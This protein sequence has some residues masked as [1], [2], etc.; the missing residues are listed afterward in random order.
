MQQIESYPQKVACIGDSITYGYSLE[1]REEDCYPA[2]L[3]RLLGESFL[4]K[5]YGHNGASLL[6]SGQTPYA[7]CPELQEAVGYHADYYVICLGTNDICPG[8]YNKHYREFI[9]DYLNLIASINRG[10]DRP[11]IMIA[12][13]PPVFMAEENQIVFVEDIV[14][15]IHDDV[16]RIVDLSDSVLMD[17]YAPLQTKREL[18]PD[19]LHPNKIGAG[20][21]AN[22]VFMAII[23][24]GND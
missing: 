2:Q 15:R 20:I 1:N 22:M 11:R 13:I 9:P 5:N 23:N 16:K 7:F 24:C 4:V 18:F 8:A 12:L 21:I 19:G 6:R 14:R 17:F 10:T 3:Q